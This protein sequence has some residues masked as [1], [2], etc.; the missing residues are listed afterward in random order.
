MKI[1][2]TFS[3]SEGLAA[4]VAGR[5][6][7]ILTGL[8]ADVSLKAMN[9]VQA[10]RGYS[11]VIAGSVEQGGRWVPEAMEFVRRFQGALSAKLF[12]IFTVIPSLSKEQGVES[13]MVVMQY[14]A[15]VRGMVLPVSEGFFSGITP[16][17][18]SHKPGERSRFKLRLLL[19]FLADGESR[20]ESEIETW[21]MQL[22]DKLVKAHTG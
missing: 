7:D 19:G 12:S 21:T 2:V 15:H 14:T 1:L 10:V 8:G 16:A 5:V 3:G 13:R 17:A 20:G 18:E 11:A 4:N 22:H 9:A 6:A